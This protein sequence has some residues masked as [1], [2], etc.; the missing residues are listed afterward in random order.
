[1]PVRLRTCVILHA[2][3]RQRITSMLKD[4]LA[5]S[6]L[7]G[8]SQP[9]MRDHLPSY[10]SAYVPVHSGI[11]IH[12]RRWKGRSFGIHLPYSVPINL[13]L[14]WII[15]HENHL[16]VSLNKA[17]L[18]KRSNNIKSLMFITDDKWLHLGFH[19]DV[20]T[21]CSEGLCGR[22]VSSCSCAMVKDWKRHLCQFCLCPCL[23]HAQFHRAATCQVEWVAA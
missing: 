22:F 7:R 16:S 6:P 23:Y 8:R 13:R 17:I 21:L 3:V 10:W 1:M 9:Y 12:M 11:H 18:P 19:G 5:C 2:A 15:V 4:H 20:H 14:F